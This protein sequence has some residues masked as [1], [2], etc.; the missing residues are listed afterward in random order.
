LANLQLPTVLPR[1]ERR[2][3]QIAPGL[4]I[5]PARQVEKCPI[6]IIDDTP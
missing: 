4:A 3:K 5:F 6:I 2:I 1:P